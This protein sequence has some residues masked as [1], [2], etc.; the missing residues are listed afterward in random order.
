MLF[1]SR[2]RL[3]HQRTELVNA[4]RAVLYE[5]GHVFPIGLCHVKRIAAVVEDP[6]CDLPALVI[7]ECFMGGTEI[8]GFRQKSYKTL[9][10]MVRKI[11]SFHF[12]IN[13][14]RIIQGERYRRSAAAGRVGCAGS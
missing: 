2:E 3:V 7:A 11:A 4:L 14:M 1:R 13:G 9:Q 10:A 12:K 5:Y 8:A 6:G